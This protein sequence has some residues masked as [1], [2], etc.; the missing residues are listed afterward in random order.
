MLYLNTVPAST[1]ALSRHNLECTHHPSPLSVA[2]GLK[3]RHALFPLA[4]ELMGV[5][6]A[7]IQIPMLAM[8]YAQEQ[9]ALAAP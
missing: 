6:G 9:L 4:D 3:P 2:R 7:V 8:V 1:E 5:L